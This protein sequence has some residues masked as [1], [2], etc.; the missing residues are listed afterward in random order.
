MTHLVQSVGV[1]VRDAAFLIKEEGIGFI[2]GE[3][4]H[5]FLR[6]RFVGKVMERA[7]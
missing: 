3:V 4:D 1:Q 5:W 6:T 7:F 2:C